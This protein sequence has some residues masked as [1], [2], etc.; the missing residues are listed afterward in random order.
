MLIY[1]R[2]SNSHLSVSASFAYKDLLNDRQFL[3]FK[4]NFGY[5]WGNGEW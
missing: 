1:Y 4:F 2:A 5:V 3:W